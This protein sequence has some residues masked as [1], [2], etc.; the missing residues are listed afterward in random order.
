MSGYDFAVENSFRLPG[1][2]D[3]FDVTRD[4][5]RHYLV[6]GLLHD[7]AALLPFLTCR[8]LTF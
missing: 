3:G 2:S 4:V 6:D 5:F 1:R 8:I 7:P